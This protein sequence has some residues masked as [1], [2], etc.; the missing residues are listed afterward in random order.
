MKRTLV[1]ILAIVAL[2][3]TFVISVPALAD[4]GRQT[5]Q[6]DSETTPA[7]YQMEKNYGPGD[8]GQTGSV[9]ILNGNNAIWIADQ[10][11]TKKVVFSSGQW[12]VEFVTESDW[13][14]DAANCNVEIGYWDGSFHPAATILKYSDYDVQVDTSK[15]ITT[16]K[17]QAGEIVIPKFAYLAVQI[18]NNESSLSNPNGYHIVY[19]GE[20]DETNPNQP[21]LASCVTSPQTDPGYPVPEVSAVILLGGG[22]IGLAAFV[23]IR[24]KNASVSA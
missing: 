12:V 14:I 11:A 16:L 18:Q 23:I 21:S 24:K 19:T 7:G 17:K 5:W 3:S 4:A 1:L 2:V 13:G 8:D 20:K 6:L 22:L 15:L 9:T 10:A